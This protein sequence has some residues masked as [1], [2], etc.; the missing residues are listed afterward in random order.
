M[1]RPKRHRIPR[2]RFLPLLL[3]PLAC[4]L[5]L[6]PLRLRQHRL[7]VQ[8]VLV[9]PLA[10]TAPTSASANVS[11]PSING[12]T[13][14][15]PAALPPCTGKIRLNAVY[16]QPESAYYSAHLAGKRL[17]SPNRSQER[18]PGA[19]W[20][21]APSSP[22]LRRALSSTACPPPSA[23]RSRTPRS[24][25]CGDQ[26]VRLGRCQALTDGRAQQ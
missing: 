1:L 17:F 12:S 7:R 9:L 15:M 22:S 13:P 11:T 4:R 14:Y 16:F 25:L 20:R 3:L 6:V 2:D 5:M 21:R 18:G 8:H 23:S 24:T 26:A 10:P 19:R